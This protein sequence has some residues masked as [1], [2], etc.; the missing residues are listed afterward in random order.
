ML[1][2]TQFYGVLQLA[3]LGWAARSVRLRVLVAAVLAGAY[4][5][6]AIAFALEWAWTRAY[7]ASSDRPVGEVT[8][9][10][11]YTVDPFIEEIAKVLPILA[12]WLVFRSVRGQWGATDLMLAVAA[13]GSGF[14][15]AESMVSF[16]TSAAHTL[17][18][19][20]GG[21][22][23]LTPFSPIL[24]PGPAAA[25]TSWLP[26]GAQQSSMLSLNAGP[27]AMNV[28]LIW[29]AMAGLGLALL[30]RG[31]AR[32]LIA[33]LCGLAL[34]GLAGLDHAAFNAREGGASA[35]AFA[36]PFTAVREHLFW[37]LPLIALAITV[38]L[39]R[40]RM[41]EQFRVAP[42]LRLGAE[43]GPGVAPGFKLA[44]LA[45]GG[46]PW[47]AL[48]VFGFVR[49]RRA[50][51]YSKA[52][53]QQPDPV[54]VAALTRIGMVLQRSS[55]PGSRVWTDFRMSR[56]QQKASSPGRPL[57]R[58]LMVAWVALAAVPVLILF[59]GGTG[60]FASL[61]S[62]FATGTGFWLLVGAA[63][64]S[65]LWLVWALAVSLI[66]LSRARRLPSADLAAP[67]GL[68]IP[69][70]VGALVLSVAA[71]SAVAQGRSGDSALADSAHFLERFGDLLLFVSLLFIIAGLFS[72]FPPLVP[73]LAGLGPASELAAGLTL[74]NAI[75]GSVGFGGLGIFTNEMADAPPES[76]G[77]ADAEP[78]PPKPG[79]YIPPPDELEA[80]PDA[81]LVR[82]KT[83]NR[84]GKKRKHWKDPS[85]GDILE[86]DSQHGRVER[87]SRRGK[88]L[89]EFNA[90]TGEQTKPPNPNYRVEP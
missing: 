42:T 77:S 44:R 27:D 31:P 13:A 47:S 36:E 29:S 51:I 9:L 90:T 39:D 41:A 8:R 61:Q 81:R 15:L 26:A 68:A 54:F 45:F 50:Y 55:W 17:S 62:W 24:V 56:A 25:V 3:L 32:S 64:V 2:V 86:W 49:M 4:G 20:G 87:Y 65:A 79:E 11:G 33:R 60:R 18:A 88:H 1:V 5:S 59:I 69:M 30:L 48:T 7:A 58:V 10:A 19:P 43:A 70:R 82:S 74:E 12:V 16:A 34:I 14:G 38:W 66:R 89:G 71:L 52:T 53:D 28:H 21:W 23:I 76:G 63:A 6:T 46:L 35:Q 57:R 72:V 40:A 37:A 22:Y 85:S 78:A 75:I 83:L 84:G 73:A 80:F 67:I